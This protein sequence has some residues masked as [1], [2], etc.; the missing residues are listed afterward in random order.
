MPF[1]TL[2][3]NTLIPSYVPVG[4]LR[5]VNWQGQIVGDSPALEANRVAHLMNQLG[6]V[7]CGTVIGE[8]AIGPGSGAAAAICGPVWKPAIT[9]NVATPDLPPGD[10]PF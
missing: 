6:T 5:F 2:V 7:N 1:L 4:D 9:P 3:L 10:V 8:H